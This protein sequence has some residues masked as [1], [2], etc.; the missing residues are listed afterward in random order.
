MIARPSH[1][2]R[3]GTVLVLF[4]LL[5]FSLFALAALVIDLGFVRL[6]HQQMQSAVETAALE[7]LRFRDD[8]SLVQLPNETPDQARRRVTSEMVAVR[9]DDDLNPANGDPLQVGAGPV[10]VPVGG[11]LPSNA[12][13]T[14]Q[15]PSL[16]QGFTY[17]Y[18][19]NGIS[20]PASGVTFDALQTNEANNLVS[21]DMVAGT[22][23]SGM[24]PIENPDYSR[25]DFTASSTATAATASSFLVRMRRTDNRNDALNNVNGV[26]THGPSLPLLF[27]R[28]T[29]ITSP[30]PAQGYAPRVHGLTV[31]ATAIAD[32]R[33]AKSIGPAYLDTFYPGLTPAFAGI[34]GVTPFALNVG[35]WS[36][37]AP[38]AFDV[39]TVAAN[40][41]MTSQTTGSNAGSMIRITGLSTPTGAGDGGLSVTSAAGFPVAPF[42]VRIDSELLLVTAVD[43]SGLNWTVTRAQQ[44]TTAAP[45]V[46]NAPVLLHAALSLGPAL[47]A[48]SSPQPNRLDLLPGQTFAVFVPFV[49]DASGLVA[50]FGKV[51]WSVVSWDATNGFKLQVA[52]QA[53]AIAPQNATAVFTQALTVT[54]AQIGPLLTSHAAIPDSI[55]VPALVR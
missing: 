45:H 29:L 42:T 4:A 38:G 9:F 50:G 12:L 6:T 41:A 46:S 17:V 32:A 8:A 11:I 48:L 55:L 1:H 15:V 16:Q 28:G 44:G 19:P 33:R 7:G 47:T 23:T 43:A 26:S 31:R 53:S 22:F 39:L 49:D 34:P 40:G 25:N 5:V 24:I 3:R 13:Q 10:L 14:L 36:A 18:K 51:K 35:Y 37:L 20:Q 52:R 54:S 30:D 2:R 27:G 21:G